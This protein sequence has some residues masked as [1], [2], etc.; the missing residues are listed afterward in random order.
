MGIAVRFNDLLN[1]KKAE[2]ICRESQEVLLFQGRS[3]RR[4]VD[5]WI[6]PR[7]RLLSRCFGTGAK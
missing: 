7:Q 6:A 1:F 5:T 4:R 2:T 3:L